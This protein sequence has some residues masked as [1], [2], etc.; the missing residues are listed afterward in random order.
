VHIRSP[1]PLPLSYILSFETAL[2]RDVMLLSCRGVEVENA[3][4]I[5]GRMGNVMGGYLESNYYTILSVLRHY[6][7]AEL[8]ILQSDRMV[9]SSSSSTSSSPS[10]PLSLYVDCASR[11]EVP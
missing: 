8:E 9:P 2:N 7:I 6:Y 4:W 5:D 10:M 3:T 1:L 11:S